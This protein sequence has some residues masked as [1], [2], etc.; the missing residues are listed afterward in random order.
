MPSPYDPRSLGIPD[1]SIARVVGEDP[2][3]GEALAVLRPRSVFAPPAR[4]PVWRPDW[5]AEIDGL[6][7]RQRGALE[8]AEVVGH[9][10][11]G[12]YVTDFPVR[13][14]TTTTQDLRLALP[15]ARYDVLDL[16]LRVLTLVGTGVRVELLTGMQLET[17]DGWVPLGSFSNI[18]IGNAMENLR[19]TNFLRY[20]RWTVTSL[21]G[22]GP[23][24]TFM[25]C[26]IG[27][28]WS[29]PAIPWRSP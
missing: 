29:P 13:V 28:T 19:F 7:W 24:A 15:V 25:L 11:R 12:I 27:R 4:S 22:T 18:T 21:T 1:E 26:G 5:E 6:P 14:T 9:R 23:S 8:R 17:A 10:P 20:I 16:E 3:T 2:I